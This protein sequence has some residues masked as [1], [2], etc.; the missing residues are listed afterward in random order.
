[1]WSL[2]IPLLK[3]QGGQPHTNKP[4]EKYGDI[5][6]FIANQASESSYKNATSQNA[7]A[8]NNKYGM[9]TG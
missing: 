9:N 8:D 2:L 4:W 3:I 1:M 7:V 6:K 5:E